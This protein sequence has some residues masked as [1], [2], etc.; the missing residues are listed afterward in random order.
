M[1]AHYVGAA[2]SESITP[3]RLVGEGMKNFVPFGEDF[4]WPGQLL[5]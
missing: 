2:P 5:T 4:S 1:E 3:R